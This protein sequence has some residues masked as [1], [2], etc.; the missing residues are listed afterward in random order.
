MC[1]CTV[2]DV[3][4]LSSADAVPD[5][6]LGVIVVVLPIAGAYGVSV[7]IGARDSTF[8]VVAEAANS[9]RELYVFAPRLPVL[10][11][12]EIEGFVLAA[13]VL[14][15][16]ACYVSGSRGRLGRR[17]GRRIGHRGRCRWARSRHDGDKSILS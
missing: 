4:F 12:E 5:N 10:L 16:D 7:R 6:L 11:L 3:I 1:G 2:S 13:P 15:S 14:G 17:S 8:D 9:K